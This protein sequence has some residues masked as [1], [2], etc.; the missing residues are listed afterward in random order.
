ML[1][2]LFLILLPGLII[3]DLFDHLKPA[4]N[5]EGPHDMRNIDFIYMINLDERPEKFQ[6][7]VSQ[8]DPYGI[9]PYRFSAVNGW[10][11]SNE[12]LNDVGVLFSEGMRADV[13]GTCYGEEPTH[14]L[15]IPGNKYVAYKMSKGVIGIV[16]SH[17]SVL[18]D[19]L[20]SGYDTIWVMEDDIL[21][22]RN[23]HLISYMIDLL[24]SQVGYGNWDIL[25][26]DQDTKDSLG[27]YVPC[28][29]AAPRPNFEPKDPDKFAE[30]K[31]VSRDF[32]KIGARY[33]TYSMILRRS[34]IQKIYDFITEHKVF[35]PY[36]MDFYLPEN[37]HMYT[38]NTE[39]ISTLIDAFSDNQRPGYED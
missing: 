34:G 27:N 24:D 18:K 35:L 12:C 13:L 7:S 37:M 2:T 6:I 33:G 36:D 28:Y 19:A 31:R 32:R 30:K 4:L 5:K 17:L 1:R 14:G 16:L 23:P 15:M 26:T 25:F 22:I 10:T 9:F 29:S 3:A 21:V 8:L 11:L 38:V 20:D 39:V